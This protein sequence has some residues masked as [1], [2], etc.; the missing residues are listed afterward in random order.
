MSVHLAIYFR[1]KNLTSIFSTIF[2]GVRTLP[3]SFSR[4]KVQGPNI[5][6][7]MPSSIRIEELYWPLLPPWPRSTGG[8]PGAPLPP[9]PAPLSLAPTPPP[10]S[11]PLPPL[12]GPPPWPL[13]LAL[14]CLGW[15]TFQPPPPCTISPLQSP[16]QALVKGPRQQELLP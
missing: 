1:S 9:A 14:G 15:T 10:P 16:P 13:A 7:T 5:D 2:S 3:R 8:P 6:P 4:S 11:A 12:P